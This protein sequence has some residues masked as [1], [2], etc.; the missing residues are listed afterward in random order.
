MLLN[1]KSEE[2]KGYSKLNYVADRFIAKAKE[3][4]EYSELQIRSL[5]LISDLA[6]NGNGV[7]SVAHSTFKKMFEQRFKMEISLSSVRRF[8]TLMQ[9]LGLI[10]INEAKRKNQQQSANIYII[11]AQS[12][13]PQEVVH[14]EH[15]IEN[16]SEHQNI[17]SK[18]TN[19][20]EQNLND[21]IVNNVE[22]ENIVND[23]YLTYRNKGINKSTFQKVLYEIKNKKGIKNFRR[24]VEGCLN[25]IVE[26]IN[27]W[28]DEGEQGSGV[29][30]RGIFALDWISN[31]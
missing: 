31:S 4:W 18:E 25:N 7:F 17:V 11:E 2:L 28:N 8:F 1:G 12:E 3:L 13:E 15:P 22:Q 14:D 19:N 20:N 23:L 5:Y 24:Y 9:K 6:K 27:K 30:P 21:N 26:Y 29:R 10:S 16:P